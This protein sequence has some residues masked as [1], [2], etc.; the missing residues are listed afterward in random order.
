M[1][2]VFSLHSLLKKILEKKFET[3]KH[4]KEI[5]PKKEIFKKIEKHNY[6]HRDFKNSIKRK[7]ERISIIGECKRATPQRGIIRQDY[8]IEKIVKEY[9][10]TKLVDAVSVLTEE[11]FFYGDLYHL[12]LARQSSNLPILR[13]DFI[14]DEYQIYESLYY[15]AD[16]ILL[17]STI[18]NKEQIKDFYIKAK[19]LS[20]EVLFEVHSLEDLEKVLELNPEVVGINNRNLENFVVDVKNTERLIKYIPKG[21]VVA[22]ESGVSSKNDIKYLSDLEIDAVLIGSYFMESSNIKD[23]VED[24]IL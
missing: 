3:I 7:K 16:A 24:L 18:L 6:V 14:I 20:L 11:H 22:S 2:E 21:V 12:V 4:K 13:K 1:N 23:A 19:S 15:E 17:I 10:L 5:L 8:N 9:S